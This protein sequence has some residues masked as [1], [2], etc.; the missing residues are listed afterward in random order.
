[1]QRLLPNAGVSRFLIIAVPALFGNPFLRAAEI[2]TTWTTGSQNWTSAANW[3]NGVPN[4]GADTF[5]ATVN[6]PNQELTVNV[7]VT[8]TALTLTAGDIRVQNQAL[9]VLGQ[10]TLGPGTPGNAFSDPAPP[11]S[12][13][14]RASGATSATVDLGV[15][16]N[17]SNGTLAQGGFRLQQTGS[18]TAV[19]RWQNAAIT[20]IASPTLISLDGSGTAIQNSVGSTDALADLQQVDGALKLSKR[21]IVV[22]GPLTNTGRLTINEV[23]IIGPGTEVINFQTGG[24]FTNSGT[25]SM[26]SN[27]PNTTFAIGGGFTNSGTATVGFTNYTP[28]AVTLSPSISGNLTNTGTFNFRSFSGFEAPSQNV[29]FNVAGDLSNTGSFSLTGDVGDLTMDFSGSLTGLVN[30]V[31]TGN[32]TLDASQAGSNVVLAVNE[33]A[34]T[35][36]AAGSSV[37][38]LGGGAEFRNKTASASALANLAQVN[39]T[40]E[41]LGQNLAVAGDFANTGSIIFG[42]DAVSGSKVFA[43][44]GALSNAGAGVLGA[45]SYRVSAAGV[46]VTSTF[47]W[48]GT[49]I[50]TIVPN[51]RVE[52]VG[53]GALLQA[54]GVDALGGLN[55][56]RGY[57]RMVGRTLAITGDFA[58]SGVSSFSVDRGVDLEDSN[59]TVGGNFSNT[60]IFSVGGLTQNSLIAVAGGVSNTGTLT[61]TGSGTAPASWAGALIAQGSLT[62][63]VGTT[64]T[65]GNYFLDAGANGTATLAWQGGDVR[66]IA[67]GVEV[68]LTGVGASLRNSA[69]NA[70]ALEN[71]STNN[72]TLTL[73]NGALTTSGPLANAGILEIDSRRAASSL[74]VG[75]ALT[76]TANILVSSVESGVDVQTLLTVNGGLNNVGT[77]EVEGT[78][79][80]TFRPAG[81]AVANILGPLVQQSGTTLTAG[82]YRLKTSANSGADQSSA[83]LAWQGAE[84]TAI[85]AN[86]T[87]VLDGQGTS[88]RNLTNNAD[89]LTGLESVAGTFESYGRNFTT[90]GN[91][92]VSGTLYHEDGDLRVTGDFSNPGNTVLISRGGTRTFTVNGVFTSPGALEV[93]A[94]GEFGVSAALFTT[95]STL[96]QNSGGVLTAG[97][98]AAFAIGTQGTAGIAWSGAQIDKIAS[99]GSVHLEG[100]GAAIRNSANQADALAGLNENAGY[101]ALGDR[102]Q[103]LSGNFLNS[104]TLELYGSAKIQMGAGTS[105]TSTGEVTIGR[106][107]EVLG[108]SLSLGAEGSFAVYDELNPQTFQYQMGSLKAG[109]VLL[110]GELQVL[111]YGL[112]PSA[113]STYV[114]IDG[115]SLTGSF[116]NVAFGQRVTVFDGDAEGTVLGSFRVNLDSLNQNVTLS[117]YLAVPEPGVIVLLAFAAGAFWWRGA[118]RRG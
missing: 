46:G 103:T 59:W 2:T 27:S 8:I 115:V 110:A 30:G 6:A 63:Q 111:L 50:T 81:H 68:S 31:L 18:G 83:V 21:G 4:N 100:A 28:N 54:S 92:G 79:T 55:D 84:I 66:T 67:A 62:Q 14:V 65:A 86:A 109:S 40:L 101:L 34:V 35:S 107:V 98:V 58:N 7:P 78:S 106:S 88:I 26:T 42:A 44:S 94:Y 22:T 70:N 60:G 97:R 90:T 20:T 36:I 1:M 37:R 71:L 15:L 9:T 5:L 25:F 53:A 82:T 61:I 112:V 52:L 89:A 17:F 47:S 117:N 99:A 16:T 72:G 57:L 56:V 108:G 75:G 48:N 64:L 95:T 85:G 113:A 77:L 91:F 24:A 69:T 10:T 3:S 32:W 19:V 29:N 45:G 80:A 33:S 23:Q 76:N 104:G 105:M 118:R 12:F 96:A 51:A 13:D 41:L 87:V 11:A 102:T 93:A 116:S 39:G 43:I 38:I 74:S 49:G 114:I 73:F